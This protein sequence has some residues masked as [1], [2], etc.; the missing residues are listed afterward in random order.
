MSFQQTDLKGKTAIV[1]GAGQGIGLAIVKALAS[2]GAKVISIDRHTSGFDELEKI[3]GAIPLQGDLADS[4]LTDAIDSVL[5]EH[6]LQLDILVNNAGIGTGGNALLATDEDFQTVF[7]V[8][9]FGTFRLSRW[10]VGHMMR[11]GSGAIVNIASIF[12]AIGAAETPVY[13]ASKGA[14]ISLTQ[15][16]A[17]DFGPN[18]IRVNAV[19][20]GLIE[21]PFNPEVLNQPW[22]R[23]LFV[24]QSPLRRVGQPVD[25]ARAVRFLVSEEASFITAQTL[26]LDGGWAVGRYPIEEKISL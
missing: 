24:E 10:A 18:N 7:E 16:M 15:Q 19:A 4:N 25:V 1:T 22:R 8:N 6:A 20:P 12:G 21:T 13:S 3:E 17:T 23:M 9:V 11:S 2:S 26:H 5:S 14:I